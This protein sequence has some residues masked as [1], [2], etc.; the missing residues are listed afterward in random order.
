MCQVIA[1]ESL[2]ILNDPATKQALVQKPMVRIHKVE[3]RE[4]GAEIELADKETGV[5][6]I[7]KVAKAVKSAYVKPT[8][9]DKRKTAHKHLEAKAKHL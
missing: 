4:N 7:K 8:V 9:V 6:S 1:K 5:K 2:A 3:A